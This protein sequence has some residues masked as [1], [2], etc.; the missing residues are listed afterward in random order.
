MLTE[1]SFPTAGPAQCVQSASPAQH[2]AGKMA[3]ILSTH[4]LH[5]RTDMMLCAAFCCCCVFENI[6]TCVNIKPL[7]RTKE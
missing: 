6:S 4:V 5:I 1:L 3:S 7:R 2:S